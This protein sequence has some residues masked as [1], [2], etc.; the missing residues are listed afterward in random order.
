MQYYFPDATLY[1]V[2]WYA[3]RDW[4]IKASYNSIPYA[5]CVHSGLK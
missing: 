3:F 2:E 1:Y 4:K 5:A